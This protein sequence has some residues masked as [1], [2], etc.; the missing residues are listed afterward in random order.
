MN[1]RKDNFCIVIAWPSGPHFNHYVS[2]FVRAQLVKLVKKTLESRHD[3]Y[4][5]NIFFPVVSAGLS[6][7]GRVVVNWN[8]LRYTQGSRVSA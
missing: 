4:F 3:Q 7:A 1:T 6:A 8:K 5:I 2:P